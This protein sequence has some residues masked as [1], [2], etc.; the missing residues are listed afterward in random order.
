M[1][2]SIKFKNEEEEEL[3][4][5]LNKENKSK[6]IDYISLSKIFASYGVVALH[7]NGFWRTKTKD[8]KIFRIVN[9]YEC[10][11]YYSV[12]IFVLCIGA[13]LLDFN[14]RYSLYEYNK[15]RFFKVF[16]P[17]LGWNIILYNYKLYFLKNISKENFNLLNL[18]NYFFSSKIYHIFDSLHTFL[19]TY[20]L[21]PLLSHVE[22][23]KKIK[24]YIYYFFILL[25]T[26]ALIPYLIKISGY[27]IVWI[28]TLKVGYIIYIFAGYIIHN[29]NFLIYQKIIIYSFGI[30]SF[31]I[32]YLG[33]EKLYFKNR[34][35][36]RLHKGYLNLPTILYSCAL[37]LVIKE[38]C[39]IIINKAN[40]KFINKIGSLTFGAFFLHKPIIE[41]LN[42]YNM[43]KKYVFSNILFCAA[44]VFSI[45]LLFSFIIRKI[46]LLKYLIP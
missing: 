19:L 14:K 44:F 37:F 18:W 36:L 2:T 26:Q 21:I 7:I 38:C 24:I 32:H 10:L 15:K 11:F 22:M 41:T 27:K 31:F 33:T 28:Y 13:T 20:L 42:G 17:L 3:K 12:P 39:F 35:K 9:F 6:I 45:C 4:P 8:V 34:M 5:N 30:I 25:I 23:N 29:H 16:L 43:T 46:P 40:K 1:H